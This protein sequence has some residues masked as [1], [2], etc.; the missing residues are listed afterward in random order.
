MYAYISFLPPVGRFAKRKIPSPQMEGPLAPKGGIKT[1]TVP[2][3]S[4][5]RLELVLNLFQ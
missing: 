1:K 4:G 5:R 2:S 3:P